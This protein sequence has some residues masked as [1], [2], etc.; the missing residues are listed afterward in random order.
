MKTELDMDK[1][2]EGLGA[3]PWGQASTALENWL[4]SLR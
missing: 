1:I 2:A 4:G 3:Q